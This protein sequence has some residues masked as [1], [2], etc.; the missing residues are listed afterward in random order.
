MSFQLTILGTGSASPVLTRNPTAHHLSIEQ[1][2]KLIDFASGV[3]KYL[4]QLQNLY[5]AL[6][7]KDLKFKTT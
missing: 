5:K 4:H 6:T 3:C 7:G 2:G 1:D